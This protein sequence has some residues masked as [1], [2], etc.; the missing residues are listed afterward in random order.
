VNLTASGLEGVRGGATSPRIK[1]AREQQMGSEEVE[2]PELGSVF[3]MSTT[4]TPVVDF[5]TR[6]MA[7][8]G[9]WWAELRAL[10]SQMRAKLF[11]YGVE[12]HIQSLGDIVSVAKRIED[13]QRTEKAFQNDVGYYGD[14]GERGAASR[15]STSVNDI[16]GAGT[17]RAGPSQKKVGSIRVK[18]TAD[19]PS[20]KHFILM[21]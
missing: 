20:A 8:P 7:R 2:P 19:K 21:K 6:M 17:S 4:G 9:Q 15:P 5:A 12:P 13:A 3:H 16:V 10:P 14:K 11:K 1:N 18:K